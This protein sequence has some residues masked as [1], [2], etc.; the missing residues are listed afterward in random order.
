MQELIVEG[1]FL[2]NARVNI[3][4]EELPLKTVSRLTPAGDGRFM[5]QPYD[6]SLSRNE[7]TRSRA[8]QARDHEEDEDGM[9]VSCL[10]GKQ[11]H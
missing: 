8:Q 6:P 3:M 10:H 4:N 7:F 1:A 2:A 5:V 9:F 11:V